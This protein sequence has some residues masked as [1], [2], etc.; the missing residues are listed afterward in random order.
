MI[1]YY[2]LLGGKNCQVISHYTGKSRYNTMNAKA[3]MNSA[4]QLSVLI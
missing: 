4:E 2:I 1:A 3:E